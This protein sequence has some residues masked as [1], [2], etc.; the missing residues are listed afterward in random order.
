VDHQDLILFHE[1]DRPL[2]LEV[3][4]ELE[5]AGAELMVLSDRGRSCCLVQFSRVEQAVAFR[6]Q[7]GQGT[8][9]VSS[10]AE[11]QHGWGIF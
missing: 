3:A 7:F 6:M 10:Y 9:T 2:P 4:R 1:P 11:A 5:R 8:T